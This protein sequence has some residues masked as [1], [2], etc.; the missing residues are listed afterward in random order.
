MPRAA[1]TT[2]GAEGTFSL[3]QL[4]PGRYELTVELAGFRK[5]VQRGL[6][7]ETDQTRRVQ[8]KL[9]LGNVA[10]A[11]TVEAKAVVINT[12]TSNKG[13]VIT[14]RQVA[15]LPLNGR[16]YT[17]LALLVPG[18]YRRPTDDGTTTTRIFRVACAPFRAF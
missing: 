10:E 13:E 9:E 4:P 6:V 8:A 2:T 12:D 15:D 7:L 18:I 14:A 17:E 1:T 16:N 11:V 5:F 3:P